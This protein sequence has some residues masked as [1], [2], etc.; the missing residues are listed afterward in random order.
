MGEAKRRLQN[1]LLKNEA[2]CLWFAASIIF[3]F[4]IWHQ[5][6]IN[7][8]TRFAVFS[9]EML[10]YGP[11]LFPTTYGQPYPDYPATSTILI[12]LFS[13]P[14]GQVTKFSAVLPTALASATVVAVTYQ[15]FSQYSKQWGMLAVGFEFLTVAFLAES[16][17]ISVDQMVSA[18]TL[19]AFCLTHKS[20]RNHL[21]LPTMKLMLL[22]IAGFMI[23]G[24]IGVVIPAGVVL[25]HLLLTAERRVIASFAVW[26]GGTLIA[27][28]VMLLGLAGPIYGKDFVSDIVRMQ[29]V[30]RF[31]ESDPSPRLYYFTSS[32]GNYALSYPIAVLAVVGMLISKWR[33]NISISNK[34]HGM[35]ILLLLAWTAIVLVGLSVPETKKARYILPIVPALAGLASYIFI[36]SDN[37][38]MRWLRR[39]VEVVFLTFPILAT[40]IL[41]TQ[42]KRF[43]PY[44]LNLKFAI[45]VFLS[46]S[47]ASILIYSFFKNR[48]YGTTVATCLIAAFTTLFFQVVIVEPIDL[49]I[50]DTGEFVR[51]IESL[52]VKQP[53]NLVFY[54]ENPDGLPIKFLVNVREETLPQFVDDLDSLK[55]VKLPVW[56]LTK[57]KNVDE[58]KSSGIDTE[59]STYRE[60]FGD[61]PFLAV[62]IPAHTVAPTSAS[63]G[64]P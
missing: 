53:G 52:R 47:I 42:K 55:N 60:K 24:P 26:S 31:A 51:H 48:K 15:L 20:Y 57:A 61:L 59:V 1:F 41:Y 21:A 13:L 38:F 4:G 28:T 14:F 30:G 9:Q 12:W 33:K 11:S 5:P 50:H 6:F 2:L 18:V 10:R 45:G 56:L 44:G 58:L 29:A 37:S 63:S 32:F 27:C 8:E 35:I 62:F 16:R 36:D 34:E 23:R 19:S 17:S 46:L 40:I 25:S 49:R 7:F 3:L 43:D 54:K 39:T 22:L 64:S